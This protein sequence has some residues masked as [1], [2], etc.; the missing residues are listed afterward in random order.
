MAAALHP[1]GKRGAAGNLIEHPPNRLAVRAVG[2]MP[3]EL[4]Q[5]ADE[6][7][8]GTGKLAELM[9]EI[10]ASRQLSR[11]DDHREAQT[12]TRSRLALRSRLLRRPTIWSATW[13]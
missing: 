10:S 1:I 13:P 7:K 8:P 9:I 3:F 6:A 12:A 11:R 2:G 5:R 4:F